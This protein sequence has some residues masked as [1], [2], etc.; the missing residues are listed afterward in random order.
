M[1]GCMCGG[2]LSA[3]RSLH[4]AI[5]CGKSSLRTHTNT[6]ITTHLELGHLGFVT[7]HSLDSRLF[8]HAYIAASEHV[9]PK[10][11]LSK[12]HRVV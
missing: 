5:Q 6:K 10:C 8:V 11:Q 12:F 4:E 2:K 3:Q 1:C 7:R 9:L